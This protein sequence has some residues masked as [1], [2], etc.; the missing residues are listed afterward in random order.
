MSPDKSI[1][2][3]WD[4]SGKIY[5]YN[6]SS[7]TLLHTFNQTNFNSVLLTEKIHFNSDAT[8]IAIESDGYNPLIIFNL[9]SYSIIKNITVLGIILDVVF[10][11]NDN[12]FLYV[13]GFTSNY[14]L[15]MYS[16]TMFP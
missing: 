7:F 4:I 13:R 6:S 3:A 14:I 12:N 16:G 15:D 10:L 2:I 1:L 8:L 11:D 5:F 9:T